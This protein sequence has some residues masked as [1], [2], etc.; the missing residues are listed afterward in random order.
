[1]CKDV[2]N[3]GECRADNVNKRTCFSCP[4]LISPAL[5]P[6]PDV[7]EVTFYLSLFPFLHIDMMQTSPQMC[8]SLSLNNMFCEIKITCL[9]KY[10][11]F[12]E[13]NQ[14]IK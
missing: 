7:L 8:V 13:R 12:K 6:I 3:N 11:L 5:S 2:T 10:L 14:T 9:D 1:M 4:Q